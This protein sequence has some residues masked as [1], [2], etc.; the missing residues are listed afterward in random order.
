MNTYGSELARYE[1]VALAIA[2]DITKGIY[3]EGE[4]VSGR[5]ILAGKYNISPETA[6][7]ALALLR[8]KE[9]VSVIPNSGTIVGSR[10][11]AQNFINTFHE[12]S[13]L[14]AMEKR[15]GQL[16][17]ARNELNRAIE[18]VVNDI[19]NFKAAMLRGMQNAEEARIRPDSWLVNRSIQEA[20][21][22]SVTGATVV[23]VQQKGRWLISPGE[24]LILQ[25]GDSL[26]V[27]GPAEVLQDFEQII[28][29]D[30]PN[31]AG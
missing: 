20:R 11:A 10:Q 12:Y 23:A 22:R 26:L 9:A 25:A 21:L 29:P 14:E 16:I 3:L 28:G 13:S 7:K 5:S 4:R 1:Q 19:V 31:D 27:V 2:L 15:L 17:K 6:R 30:K 24:D 8:D 18:G